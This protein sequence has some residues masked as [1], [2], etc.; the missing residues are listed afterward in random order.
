MSNIENSRFV[1]EEESYSSVNEYLALG[2]TLTGQYFIDVGE[3]GVPSQRVRY[4]LS[5]QNSETEPSYPESSSYMQ[6]KRMLERMK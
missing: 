5:W 1:V 2:W 4:I 3:Y 6:Q